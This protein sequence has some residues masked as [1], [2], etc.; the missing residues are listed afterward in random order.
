MWT[1]RRFLHSTGLAVTAHA[2]LPVSATWA[3]TSGVD[4]PLRL[5]FYTDVH[6]RT[7]WDT[8]VAMEMTARSINEQSA[9]LVLAGGDL[10]TDGYQ[11]SASIVEPRWDAYMSV[12]HDQIKPRVEA[13]LGNHDLVAVQPD[14]GSKPAD[15]PR[16]SF[17]SRMKL[18]R[19]YRSVDAGGYRIFILD[20]IEITSDDLKY[21]GYINQLQV[22]W[23][24]DEL[25]RTDEVTPII[26]MSHLPLMTGF[27]MATKAATEPAPANRVVVNNREVLNL[28]AKHNLMLVLQGHLHVDEML[29][30]GRTTFI[31]GGAVCAQYWRGPWHGTQEGYG[32]LTLRKDRVDWQYVDIGWNAKRPRDQ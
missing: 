23:L 24:E 12:L 30:W 6:A 9:D 19:T 17:L 25:S 26:L 10:I 21:R 14:D 11:S 2:A 31:T 8:P 18:D 1:R 5:V 32:V 7:E 4:S 13:M 16:G 3:A 29:R 28:F 15:E 22:D 20:S 27:F